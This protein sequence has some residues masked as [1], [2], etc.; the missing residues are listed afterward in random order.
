MA[1]NGVTYTCKISVPTLSKVSDGAVLTVTADAVPP[2]VVSVSGT[3]G[4]AYVA[5]DELLDATT[6]GNPANYTVTGGSVSGAKL[7][8]DGKTVQLTVTGVTGTSVSVTTT[9]VKDYALN[10]LP[11]AVTKSGP[12]TSLIDADVGTRN[13]NNLALFT[14]PL[15][16][17][18]VTVLSQ[19]D[20]NIL[21]GGSDIWNNADGMNFLYKQI[22][23]DFD[24]KVQMADVPII[25]TWTKGG[26]M[27]RQDLEG[28]SREFSVLTS[29][30]SLTNAVGV[31]GQNVFQTQYRDTKGSATIESPPALRPQLAAYPNNW[32]RLKRVGDTF[33]SFWG[34]NGVDWNAFVTNAPLTPFPATVYVGL[35]A[36][37]HD[38]GAGRTALVQFRNFGELGSVT[39]PTPPTM[40]MSHQAGTLVLGW[41][42]AAI[43]FKLQS[44]LVVPTTT[45]QD[46]AGSEATNS[47]TITI[48]AGNQ[49]FRL[50]K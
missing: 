21:A 39:P 28:T 33:Y 19:T 40:T 7:L 45:W 29:A 12:Q 44:S 15:E 10:T 42:T 3:Q 14:D 49:Y 37:S 41:P 48:G 46:V 1:Y 26:L 24:V 20:F 43:G 17:G 16:P 38:N 13:T 36:T 22:T 32:V 2:T 35:A 34:T 47:V 31:V 8:G 27:V 50:K 25:N 18:S 23:G 5:F 30:P 6:A 4:A 11:A 9:G